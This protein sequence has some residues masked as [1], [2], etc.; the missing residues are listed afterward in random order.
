MEELSRLVRVGVVCCT[1]NAAREPRW[2]RRNDIDAPVACVALTR[3]D[4]IPKECLLQTFACRRRSGI[5]S[6][7]G[8]VVPAISIRLE[9]AGGSLD[10]PVALAPYSSAV[11]PRE[12]SVPTSFRAPRTAE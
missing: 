7:T 4:V 10:L 12:A 6:G 5:G 11:G 2:Q 3:R 1:G 9:Q 8:R